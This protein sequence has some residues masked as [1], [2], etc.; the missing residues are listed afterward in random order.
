M[1]WQQCRLVALAIHTVR[2]ALLTI[3]EHVL[4]GILN[5]FFQSDG[6]RKGDSG[7]LDGQSGATCNV[8]VGKLTECVLEFEDADEFRVQDEDT[9]ATS[10]SV[11]VIRSE[12]GKGKEGG[13]GRSSVNLLRTRPRMFSRTERTELIPSSLSLR[14]GLRSLTASEGEAGQ[15]VSD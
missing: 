10:L 3:R 11:G 4:L 13:E 14:D 1:L 5:S 8:E 2:R 6:E 7:K 9:G 12:L 15:R